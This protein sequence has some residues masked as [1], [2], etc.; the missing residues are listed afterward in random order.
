MGKS[1]L[2]SEINIGSLRLEN[3]IVIPPMCQYSAA[4]GQATDWHLMH[5]G[6]L[7]LSGAGL[8]IVEAT[9]VCPEGRISYADLGLWDKNTASA[10]EKTV[11]FIRMHSQMPL[12]VQLG[13]AGRKASTDLGWRPGGSLPPDSANGWQT[14]APSPIPLGAG[15]TI[16]AEL[17]KTEIK[18]IV[19]QFVRAAGYAVSIGFDA[20]ELHAAH[21]YLIHQFLSPVTNKRT[22]E[23]GG[24]LE[25]RMRFALEIFEAVQSGLPAGFPVGTRISATDW[26]DGGWDPEQSVIF[27]KEL[28]K[29]GCA[30]IHVSAGGLDGNLQKMPEP[31]PGYQLPFAEAIKKEVMMPVIGVGLITEPEQAEKAL[32]EGKA[33]LIAIGRNMLYNPRWGWHAAAALGEQVTAPSQ[34]QRS[35]P[36]KYKNLFRKY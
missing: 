21:G 12:A 10:L 7:A 35:Q 23:Y 33:D 14:V 11:N 17:S 8:L 30:Y 16:P 22:D 9:A 3:R 6:N 29:R 20:I 1:K 24:S 34:Y 15:G 19:S 32:E 13:H 5:Y 18:E 26:I 2:F 25:N 36:H 27:A 31:G 28:D 4:N